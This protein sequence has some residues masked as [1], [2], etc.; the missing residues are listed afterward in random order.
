M[1]LQG[2]R[3]AILVDDL[4]EDQEFWYP[5]LRMKEEGARVTVVSGKKRATSKHG[6]PAPKPDVTPSE[7]R[8]DRF[9][10][11]IVPGGY[12]PDM[13]RRDQEVL[14]FVREVDEA[15]KPIAAICHAGW[16]LI[17]AGICDG[18]TMTGFTSIQDD[19]R[20]AGA[21]YVD[22]EVVRDGNIIT[23]RH[24]GDLPAFCRELIGAIAGADGGRREASPQQRRARQP[25][26][27][28]ANR[29]R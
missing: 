4:Y 19:L 26:Q 28:P 14:R 24:P 27:A 5:Y 25:L 21:E 2:K 15:R 9:D 23:S 3:V 17:S 1:R 10:A 29:S 13:L 7:A 16:V 18:R 20:N 6:V 11:L 8:G 12:A 22:R